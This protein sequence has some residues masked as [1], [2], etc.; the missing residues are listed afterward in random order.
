MRAVLSSI[1]DA[2]Q[3]ETLVAEKSLP[4][5]AVNCQDGRRFYAHWVNTHGDNTFC[6]WLGSSAYPSLLAVT[7][8]SP[9]GRYF[10]IANASGEELGIQVDDFQLDVLVY[11]QPSGYVKYC[12]G[13]TCVCYDYEDDD[14]EAAVIDRQLYPGVLYLRIAGE[15]CEPVYPGAPTTGCP[16]A[17]DETIALEFEAD[18]PSVGYNGWYNHADYELCGYPFQFRV[19]CDGTGMLSLSMYYQPYDGA[20]WELIIQGGAITLERLTHTC[21]PIY[22]LWRLTLASLSGFPCCLGLTKGKYDIEIFA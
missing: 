2:V 20:E 5:Q 8:L 13:C 18:W 15:C 4:P 19:E 17:V 21:T 3:V 6:V 7:G 16:A 10:G 22:E 1:E 9:P 14:P 11:E 12:F